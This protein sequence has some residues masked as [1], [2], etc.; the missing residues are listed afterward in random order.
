VWVD[1][2]RWG[3][4]KEVEDVAELLDVLFREAFRN[5]F[6]NVFALSIFVVFV[7]GEYASYVTGGEVLCVFVGIGEKMG[8]GAGA[9]WVYA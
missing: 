6:D 4:I 9:G 3:N 2:V 8:S 5:P 1:V 7:L